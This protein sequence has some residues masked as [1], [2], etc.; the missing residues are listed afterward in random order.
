MHVGAGEIDGRPP[1][2][3]LSFAHLAFPRLVGGRNEV[4]FVGPPS[5][6]SDLE[7][8]MARGEV[9]IAV[10]LACE[11]RKRRNYQS[12]KSRRSTPDRIDSY[13]VD[14]CKKCRVCVTHGGYPSLLGLPNPGG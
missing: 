4:F 11:E 2:S 9:R 1:Q 3:A 14:L 10:T 6:A 5:A 12:N 7:E 13:D 8:Q